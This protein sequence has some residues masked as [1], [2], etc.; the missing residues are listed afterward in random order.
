MKRNL[1]HMNFVQKKFSQS[2]GL[3]SHKL[4]H[5][6]VKTYHCQECEY[7]CSR[8]HT[9]TEHKRTHTKEK[10][11][12]CTFCPIAFST[13]GQ[14]NSHKITHRS[15]K[16]SQLYSVWE[17]IQTFKISSCTLFHLPALLIIYSK[18]RVSI[19]TLMLLLSMKVIIR[20]KLKK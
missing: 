15:R 10:P 13:S 12:Q 2:G 16:A 20:L 14:L 6:T 17:N 4:T 5:N 18:Y 3:N 1:L 19:N 7:S 11:Y 8:S 9:L